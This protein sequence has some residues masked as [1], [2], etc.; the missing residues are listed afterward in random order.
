MSWDCVS[1]WIEH[2][3]GLASWIQAVGSIGAIIGAFTVSSLQ[4][5]GQE[6]QRRLDAQKKAEAFYAVIENAVKNSISVAEMVEKQP[7]ELVFRMAWTIHLGELIRTALDAMKGI[8]VH[9][10]GTYE[11]V[12][13]YSTVVGAISKLQ[14]EVEKHM[15][16]EPKQELTNAV[17]ISIAGQANLIRHGWGEF[18]KYSRFK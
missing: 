4:L 9:E 2:H 6:R 13:H 8:P 11:L 15:S 7:P 18:Q 14:Y 1:Y 17:Y 16:E 3:P 5:R 10:L 12:L